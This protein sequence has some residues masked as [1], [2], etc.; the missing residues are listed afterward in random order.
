MRIRLVFAVRDVF[1]HGCGGRDLWKPVDELGER[2]SPVRRVHL[3]GHER[4]GPVLVVPCGR[5]PQDP[6]RVAAGPIGANGTGEDFNATMGGNTI[7]SG[8]AGTANGVVFTLI[9][10]GG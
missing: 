7:A 2:V 5:R 8:T 10:N 3:E 4:R 1:A 6:R 9:L